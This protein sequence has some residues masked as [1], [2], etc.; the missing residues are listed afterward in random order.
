MLLHTT[1]WL[2]RFPVGCLCARKASVYNV[3]HRRQ[4]SQ[5]IYGVAGCC[6]HSY[7]SC[8]MQPEAAAGG[9]VC[10]V[11]V[12]HLLA[13]TNV[14]HHP[15]P[16]VDCRLHRASARAVDERVTRRVQRESASSTGLAA[17]QLQLLVLCC[18]LR[19][20]RRHLSFAQ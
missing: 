9:C 12:C 19:G 3:V 11:C 15:R 7:S 10:V 14:L 20:L 17:T 13:C 5:P 6:S 4:T 2:I 8:C 16:S 1:H 18:Q